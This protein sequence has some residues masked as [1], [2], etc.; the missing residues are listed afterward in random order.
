MGPSV[1]AGGRQPWGGPSAEGTAPDPAKRRHRPVFGQRPPPAGRPGGCAPPA[2]GL[3]GSW[4]LLQGAP[5][6]GRGAPG[7]V[8]GSR[9]GAAGW[10]PGCM[11]WR[12]RSW[13]SPNSPS[14]GPTLPPVFRAG[15]LLSAAGPSPQGAGAGQAEAASADCGVPGSC[16]APGPV[17][18][19]VEGIVF[20]PQ[21]RSEPVVPPPP[22]AV[23]SSA[24]P[25][26]RRPH[27]ASCLAWPARCQ[28][29]SGW[30][31]GWGP[32][33][34]S[35]LGRRPGGPGGGRGGQFCG[36]QRSRRVALGEPPFLAGKPEG[37][38]D[39]TRR[40]DR[41]QVPQAHLLWAIPRLGLRTPPNVPVSSRGDSLSLCHPLRFV[42]RQA[43]LRS[44]LSYARSWRPRR[45]RGL[46]TDAP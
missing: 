12:G 30:V 3:L 8:R 24:G 1:G 15:G 41:P 25:C 21:G 27:A 18:A 22:L 20:V 44:S 43:S 35:H 32:A 29:S 28:P 34:C 31:S 6:A 45:P 13:R 14:W 2:G 38:G 36:P 42:S 4:G 9:W 16:A 37:R 11:E 10:F 39:R 23:G 7:G 5:W 40:T 26:R 17:P 46:H 33:G 19:W